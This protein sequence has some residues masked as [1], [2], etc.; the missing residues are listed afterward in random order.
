MIP[1][2]QPPPA[3]PGRDL[4]WC[5]LVGQELNCSKFSSF[6]RTAHLAQPLEEK[7]FSGSG[8]ADESQT[9]PETLGLVLLPCWTKI[10]ALRPSKRQVIF[11]FCFR[12][13]AI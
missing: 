10:R 4:R 12:I 7:T 1:G 11:V 9:A 5:E 2:E 8:A 13:M 3:Q 6:S